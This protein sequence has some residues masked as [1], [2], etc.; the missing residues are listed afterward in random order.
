[1]KNGFRI[2]FLTLLLLAAFVSGCSTMY[3][4]QH[5]EQTVYFDSNIEGTEVNCSG[6]N[7][8]TPG[9]LMLVQSKNHSCSARTDGYENW[10][11]RVRSNLS[12]E[13]FD[14]STSVNTAKWGWWTLGIGTV[15]GWT[16]DVLSGSMRSLEKDSYYIDMRPVGSVGAGKKVLAKTMSVGKAIVNIPRDVVASTTDATLDSTIRSGSEHL[17]LVSQEKRDHVESVI[18]GK[19]EA[20]RLS[21]TYDS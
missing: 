12:K 20:K 10:Y 17:G 18:D 11:F 14:H 7:T 21:E 6:K 1:M 5:D 19:N 3:G 8:I 9:N 16:V 4:R 2:K 13:G 15:I